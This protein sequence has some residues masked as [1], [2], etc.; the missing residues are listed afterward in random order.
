M[1]VGSMVEFMTEPDGDM[2]NR[3]M[4]Y[5]IGKLITNGQGFQQDVK[6]PIG[7]VFT[8]G[9]RDTVRIQTAHLAELPADFKLKY[10]V[11]LKDEILFYHYD[12]DR[13]IHILENMRANLQHIEIYDV[14][15][16]LK[17]RQTSVKEDVE[18]NVKTK[19]DIGAK[20]LKDEIEN[21][22]DSVSISESDE[23]DAEKIRYK[24]IKEIF[25]GVSKNGR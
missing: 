11:C 14:G 4:K 24:H 21:K 13:I 5:F 3:P 12:I 10:L 9:L 18:K 25:E 23:T 2:G 8:Y 20:Q 15:K 22:K 17:L 19:E 16:K 7:A 6:L 1:N